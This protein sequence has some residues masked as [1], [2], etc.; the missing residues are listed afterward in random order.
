MEPRNSYNPQLVFTD[1]GK[2]HFSE[3][4]QK[5]VPSTTPLQTVDIAWCGQYILSDRP[6]WATDEL[7]RI[8]PTAS[9]QQLRD[10]KLREFEAVAFAGTF[11]YGN[12]KGLVS[13]TPFI[14]LDIDD[15]ASTAEARQVQAALV[16]DADVVTALCFVSPKALGVKWVVEQP[17]WCSD[18]TFAA[19]YEA[20][21][22]YLGYQYGLQADL[23][24][25][26]VNRLCFLPHDEKCYINP[27]YIRQ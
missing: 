13:R 5:W 14:C 19:Q 25:S 3:K 27:K 6:T 4:K 10:F 18:L 24:C 21:S 23:S 7:R 9:E 11:T 20:L 1:F 26:N 12:A 2:G 17:Q 16:A 8:M 22:R 15:L